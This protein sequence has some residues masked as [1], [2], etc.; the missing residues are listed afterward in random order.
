[1]PWRAGQ[2]AGRRGACGGRTPRESVRRGGD[3]PD[4]RAPP[5]GGLREGKPKRAGL[6]EG[7]KKKTGRQGDFWAAGIK[8]KGGGK[9]E[10]WAW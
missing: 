1:L 4:R 8:I 5:V 7:K 3:D 6:P 9:K 2:A 10:G